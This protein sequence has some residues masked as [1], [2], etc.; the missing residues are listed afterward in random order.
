MISGKIIT[1]RQKAFIA[2]SFLYILFNVFP[3]FSDFLP[4]SV[5]QVS[6][7]TII[8]CGI[9]YPR[10][11][12]SKP[13]LWLYIFLI[14][15]TVNAI[16]ERY[17]HVNGLSNTTIP[18]S[19]RIIIEAAWI[20][21]SVM[22]ATILAASKNLKLIRIVGWGSLILL[23]ISFIYLLP[24]ISI[25][26]NK[27]R[28]L[29]LSDGYDVPRGLPSYTLMHSYVLM[30]PG[31]CLAYRESSLR[32]RVMFGI[33]VLLFFYL[34]LKTAVTTS[35]GLS[36]LFIIFA[37]V[38]SKNSLNKTLL[39][40]GICIILFIIALES[41]LVL[42]FINWIMPYFE[43]TAVSDKLIDFRNSIDV[44]HLTGG[45]ILVRGNLHE[46]SKQSFFSN[47]FFGG[48]QVGGHSQ[49][50]D[51]LGSV[52]LVG[53]IP[54]VMII[55]KVMQSYCPYVSDKFGRV[56]LYSCFA[57]AA[58]Y[59]YSKGIFGATG[60]LFMCVLGPC[61]VAAVSNTSHNKT[62]CHQ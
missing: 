13:M 38:V 16:L 2:V 12:I 15:L 49:F 37:L 26:A 23:I 35:I 33:I 47:P 57:L 22:I 24:L 36:S 50:L 32:R 11:L 41:G 55:I 30:L 4:I 54:F 17:I 42:L 43:G 39:L 29:A 19:T 53:F 6:I 25:S 52:G 5:Q 56:F 14:V 45:T 28:E 10:S 7:V 61:L 40:I 62:I 44:G 59:L 31:L 51:I 58:V 3:L 27:L 9:L 1:T 34:I 21:P 18:A 8:I 20:L 48:D 60:W 46:L